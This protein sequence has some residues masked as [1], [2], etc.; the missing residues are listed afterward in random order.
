[1]RQYWIPNFLGGDFG[2]RLAQPPE[3]IVVMCAPFAAQKYSEELL[4]ENACFER[5]RK[6]IQETQP[7]STKQMAII[8]NVTR[9]LK[10]KIDRGD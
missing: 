3:G 7:E 2:K 9:Q 1:M 6:Q 8:N 5:H 4:H 10:S